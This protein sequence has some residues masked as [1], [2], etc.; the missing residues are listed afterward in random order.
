MHTVNQYNNARA[1]DIFLAVEFNRVGRFGV[2]GV[3]FFVVVVAGGGVVA[4]TLVALLWLV[5]D[6]VV[7]GGVVVVVIVVPL[8]MSLLWLLTLMLLPKAWLLH[9]ALTLNK[10]SNATS[11][12]LISIF[13]TFLR[14]KINLIFFPPWL[15]DFLS[16][17]CS[18][19]HL[20]SPQK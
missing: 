20:W 14:E 18:R 11:C 15:L 13:C 19:V 5:V 2:I 9:G 17:V 1:G 3:E 10:E 7:C 6:A 16:C 12:A 8:S 4:T